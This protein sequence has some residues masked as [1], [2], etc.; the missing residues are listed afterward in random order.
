MAVRHR[1]NNT[2]Q[3]M[4]QRC[5]NTNSKDFVNYGGRGIEV[6]DRWKESFEAF[7][8]DMYPSYISGLT[9]DR[10]DNNGNYEPSNCRWITRAEQNGNRRDNKKIT[11]QGI[12]MNLPE[13]ARHFNIKRSTLAQRVYVYKWPTEKCFDGRI[14]NW[15]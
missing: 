8:E 3:R 5:Y 10:I 6:C 2:W 12:T 4:K 14:V 9:L 11:Y 13:W 7:V 1:L 15:Q